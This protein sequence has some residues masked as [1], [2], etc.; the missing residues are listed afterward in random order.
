MSSTIPDGKY[1][2]K[3]IKI[4]NDTCVIITLT[5][6][7]NILLKS[8]PF[9]YTTNLKKMV[10]VIRNQPEIGTVGTYLSTIKYNYEI[11]SYK[12]IH[13]REDLLDYLL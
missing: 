5:N 8:K 10:I 1:K 12:I 9:A 3:D 2:V 4:I 11:D 7:L 6:D 13:T